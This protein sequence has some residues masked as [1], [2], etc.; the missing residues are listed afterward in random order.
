MSA[1]SRIHIISVAA[2]ATAPATAQILP[3]DPLLTALTG[4]VDVLESRAANVDLALTANV[5]A[6]NAVQAQIAIDV[7]AIAD[8]DARVT[9]NS[10][11]IATNAVRADA[12]DLRI[13][14]SEA[15]ALAQSARL[16]V[17]ETGLSASVARD[18][19]Q[20]ALLAA[21]VTV[22]AG[23]DVRI[24]AGEAQDALQDGL[25]ATNTA[26][27]ATNAA[28]IAAN[29]LR[30]NGQDGLI[31]AN[32]AAIIANGVRDDAQDVSI[33][34]TAARVDQQDGRIAANTA[35][36]GTLRADVEAG[37][38]GLMRQATPAGPI[39]VG[40]ATG[41]DSVSFAG[42]S[43][44]RRL[45]GVADGIAGNDAATMGQL[46]ARSTATLA[47]A[48]DYTDRAMTAL[49]DANE[50]LVSASNG[51]LRRDMRAIASGTTAIAGL[52]QS[53]IPGKGMVGMSMGGTGGEMAV[54]LGLS[55]AF[56]GDN[57]LVVRGGLAFD[58]RRGD[59]TY[60]AAVGIHF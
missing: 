41:G 28:A 50:R 34:A 9:V 60:N 39:S 16:A 8:L 17:V 43:G 4:R 20:D 37:R 3:I 22:N 27:I 1:Y 33:A 59:A 47:A 18:A 21:N 45:S 40:A 48:N 13:A 32:A 12:Q 30:D 51:V 6:L 11:L 52:P 15:A 10:T 5:S 54:A 46:A 35:G 2:L 42:T 29:V 25:I 7:A 24:A 57:P 23:Q 56:E 53:F 44:D 55:K 31:A 36:L 26:A 49:L 14:A 38:V 19:A 58:T